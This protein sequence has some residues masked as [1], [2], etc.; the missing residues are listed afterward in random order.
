MIILGNANTFLKSHKGK[1]PWQK[2]FNVLKDG[3]HIYDGLPV[4]CAQHPGRQNMLRTAE[5]FDEQCPDGGCSEP[6]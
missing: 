3:G 5:D 4:V 1:E 6:W 2:L